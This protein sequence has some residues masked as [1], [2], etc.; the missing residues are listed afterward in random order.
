MLS[1]SV[2]LLA[3]VTQY[4]TPE[5]FPIPEGKELHCDKNKCWIELEHP[6]VKQSHDNRGIHYEENK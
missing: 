6:E 3:S 1:L 4:P 5:S 2:V